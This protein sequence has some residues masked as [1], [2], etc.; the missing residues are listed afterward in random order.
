MNES[1]TPTGGAAGPE[2]DASIQPRQPDR[3]VILVSV[4]YAF[5]AFLDS[6]AAVLTALSWWA[7]H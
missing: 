1:F 3:S 4:L 7:C 6:A 2:G 5:A